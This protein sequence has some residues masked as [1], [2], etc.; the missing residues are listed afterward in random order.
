M[1]IWVDAQLSPFI[2]LFINQNFD[3]IQASSMRSLNMQFSTDHEIFKA[4][5]AEKV[6]IMSK[7]AD[8]VK[9]IE[10]YDIPPQLIW[11]TCG[12]TS[13]SKMCSILKET[14]TQV[15]S[16]LKNGEKVVEISG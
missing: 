11:I 10:L 5:R 7:D 4:A 12:N 16:L 14:L 15:A 2:A 6:V 3:E 8:F 9:L 1:R 13:N